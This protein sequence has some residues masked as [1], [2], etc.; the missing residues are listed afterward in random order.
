MGS[1][2]KILMQC[3]RKN[4]EYFQKSN[5]LSQRQ[6]R[7]AEIVSFDDLVIKQLEAKKIPADGL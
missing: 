2:L 1:N 5:V 3:D 4:V 6:A 7:W